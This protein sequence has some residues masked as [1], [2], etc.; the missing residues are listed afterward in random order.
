VARRQARLLPVHYFHV[1]FTLPAEL[2]D[3]A[4]RN[5]AALFDLLL[6]SAAQ[7][8]LTLARDPKW[9]GRSAR[10]GVTAVLHTWTRDLHFHPHSAECFCMRS[11]SAVPEEE[12]R[13]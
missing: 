11:G 8:L 12:A 7:A 10:L 6:K 5:R 1:V 13:Y 3:I 4:A 9:L 2:R